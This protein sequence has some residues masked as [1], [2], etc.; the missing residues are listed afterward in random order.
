[1]LSMPCPALVTQ[2]S[3]RFDGRG[4]HSRASLRLCGVDRCCMVRSCST[5]G[6]SLTYVTPAAVIFA[7][8]G[9]PRQGSCSVAVL[10]DRT[11]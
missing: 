6:D 8:R 3:S 4:V 11:D 10:V 5:P 1:V 9:S 2:I 7:A